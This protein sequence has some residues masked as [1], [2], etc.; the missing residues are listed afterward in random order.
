MKQFL[1]LVILGVWGS[2]L[3]ALIIAEATRTKYLPALAKCLGVAAFVI[4]CFLVNYQIADALDLDRGS[5]GY[6]RG[7]RVVSPYGFV[8]TVLLIV[9]IGGAW[10]LLKSWLNRK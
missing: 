10:V 2:A 9:E 1:I 5:S 7:R 3:V 4:A 6:V 8:V